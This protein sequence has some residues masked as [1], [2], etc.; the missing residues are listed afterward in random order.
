MHDIVEKGLEDHLAGVM[1]REFDSHVSQCSRCREEV[2]GMKQFSGM[3]VS[4]RPNAEIAPPLGFSAR[5]M[6]EIDQRE[7]RSIWSVFTL[8]PGFIRKL[9][10]ASLLGLAAFGSYLASQPEDGLTFGR[11]TPEAVMASHDLSVAPDDPQHM[12]GMLM[13]LATYQQ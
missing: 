10:V 13:T 5:L 3:L 12:N 2:E 8:D 1:N 11:H 6:R 4:L 9:A 7:S